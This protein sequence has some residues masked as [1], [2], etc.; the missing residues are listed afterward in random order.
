MNVVFFSLL[1]EQPRVFEEFLNILA[2]EEM[3]ED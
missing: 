1:V 2:L 3:T